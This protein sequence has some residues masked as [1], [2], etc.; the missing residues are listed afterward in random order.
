MFLVVVGVAITVAIPVVSIE[1]QS[2]EVT[3]GAIF[4]ITVAV[5]N[6]TDMGGNQV[7]VNFDPQAM[8]VVTIMEGSFLKWAGTTIGAG[9]EQI[10]N[11]NGSVT[12]LYALTTYGAQVSGSG[13]L[14]TIEFTADPSCEGQFG[15]TLSNVLFANGMGS[16]LQPIALAN[17]SVMLALAPDH[18]FDTRSGT[19]P[20]IPGTH[21]GTIT[22]SQ[23]IAISGLY[24]YPCPNTGGHT[25]YVKIWNSTNWDVTATWNGYT[26][27]W[28]NLSFNNSFTLFANQTYNYTIRT[29][30][31]PQ[32]IHES[33]W[34]ATG[35]VITCEEFVD[36]NGKR[37]KEWIP[38]IR[39]S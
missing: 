11:N 20:S 33:P 2:Q 29:G 18:F 21:T 35:G 36:I 7:T 22:P 25:E 13:S 14:A 31:Y 9:M 16:Q 37:H 39:L 30:S 32:I 5:K 6:V 12:F 3:S 1:P 28:H 26:S 34:N 8:R 19:Y 4:T 27:D 23:D 15:I 24:T 38:A 17:G 10:D